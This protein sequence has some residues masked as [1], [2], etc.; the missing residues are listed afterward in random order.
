MT[1]LCSWNINKLSVFVG[2]NP[3][4]TQKED[5]IVLPKIVDEWTPKENSEK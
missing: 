4:K 3:I 1:A 2:E 5:D